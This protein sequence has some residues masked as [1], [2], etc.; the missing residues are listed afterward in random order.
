M[1]TFE[2]STGIS[3]ACTLFYVSPNQVNFLIPPTAAPGLGTL[4]AV[5]GDGT[6]SQ[7]TVTLTATAPGVYG[8][9]GLAAALSVTATASGTQT[10]TVLLT[11]NAAGS[12]VTTPISLDPPS[13]TVYLILYGTGIRGAALSQVSVQIAGTT[14][15]PA[16]AGAAPGFPGEDQVNVQLPDS[17]KGAGS[18]PVTVVVAGQPSNSVTIQIQ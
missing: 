12:L 4:T 8:A 11:A 9:N 1:L 6:T 16:Y 17:L 18:V 3:Q 7:G 2:D 15:A 13:N 14:L 5:S 10:T